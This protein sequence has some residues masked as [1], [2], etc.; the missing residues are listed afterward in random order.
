MLFEVTHITRFSYSRPVF[1]EPLTIRLKPRSDLSQRL[2]AFQMRF[3][4]AAT[5]VSEASDVEGNAVLHAWFERLLDSLT[6][7]TCFTSETL[8]PNPFD[9]TVL[10]PAAL[11]LPM[12]YGAAERAALDRYLAGTADREVEAFAQA[13]LRASGGDAQAF[14]LEL[15]ARICR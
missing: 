7:T 8:R 6:L 5:G 12:R 14:L 15:A 2:L 9:Y 13:T 4:P 3:D 10:D 1:V 11:R